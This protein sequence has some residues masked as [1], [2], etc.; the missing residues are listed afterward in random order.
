MARLFAH[1][2]EVVTAAAELG[3]Q[4]A[5]G[6]ALIAPQLPPFDVPAGHTEDSWLRHL[7]MAGA[8][9]RYGAP[10]RAPRAYAQIEHELEV[11]ARLQFPGYFLV[12]HDITR[13][14]RENNILCQGRGSAANSAVCYAL[15]VTNVDP[16]ANEL[17]FERFYPRHGTGRRISTST[18][19]RTCGRRPSSTS[20]TATAATTPRRSPTS[21]PTAAAARCAT[22]PARWGS[23]RASRTR[24]ASRSAVGTGWPTHPT[25]K[26]SR[27]R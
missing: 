25:S 23:P 20:T 21:S 15:G 7:V 9:N 6:L 5:F 8:R 1:R 12:V 17:L 24:G 13:F 26:T 27:N 18:S 10:E 11:I 14:C 3:E 16:I 4:C 19:N 22:W 2:P